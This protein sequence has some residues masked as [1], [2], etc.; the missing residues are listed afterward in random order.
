MWQINVFYRQDLNSLMVSKCLYFSQEFMIRDVQDEHFARLSPPELIKLAFFCALL[1]QTPHNPDKELVSRRYKLIKNFFEE[2]TRVVPIESLWSAMAYSEDGKCAALCKRLVDAL[3]HSK[4]PPSLSMWR[5]SLLYI[6]QQGNEIGSE[7]ILNVIDLAES[8]SVLL[9]QFGNILNAKTAGILFK[10]LL[11][12]M[13]DAL[14][15][16]DEIVNE[17]IRNPI[18]LAPTVLSEIWSDMKGL[19]DASRFPSAAIS[20]VNLHYLFSKYSDFAPLLTLEEGRREV[21]RGQTCVLFS[22]QEK[23]FQLSIV[24]SIVV[25]FMQERTRVPLVHDR[26]SLWKISK[27]YIGMAPMGINSLV[28]M[29][30]PSDGDHFLSFTCSSDEESN[31]SDDEESED[32]LRP[33]THI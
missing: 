28:P 29:L 22:L 23:T 25:A 7:D 2:S 13:G 26:P 1:E 11:I 33:V 4:I 8:F 32:I 21:A 6:L 9:M 31:E 27:L 18:R 15:E 10:V 30:K 14:I 20:S 16:D 17:L 12:C 5:N 3:A 24:T 19:C